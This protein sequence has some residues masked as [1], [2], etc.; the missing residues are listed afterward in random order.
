MS[1]MHAAHYNVSS[2]H[3]SF[4]VSK[5]ARCI[6]MLCTCCL[7]LLYKKFDLA[8]SRNLV[9]ANQLL[10]EATMGVAYKYK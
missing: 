1:E 9:T 6:A 10:T 7:L 8:C 2:S 3:T 4:M 5:L